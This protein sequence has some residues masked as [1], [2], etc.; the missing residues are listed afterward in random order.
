[1]YYECKCTDLGL[2]CQRTQVYHMYMYSLLLSYQNPPQ[3]VCMYMHICMCIECIHT[4]MVQNYM[5]YMYNVHEKMYIHMY[6]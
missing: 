4:L 5:L 6:I 2:C 3:Q 1:M